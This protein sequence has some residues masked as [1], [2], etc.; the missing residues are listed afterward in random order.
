MNHTLPSSVIFPSQKTSICF[1]TVRS[2]LYI[3]RSAL[4]NATTDVISTIFSREKSVLQATFSIL[5]QLFGLTTALVGSLFRLLELLQREEKPVRLSHFCNLRT[6]QKFLCALPSLFSV[7]VRPHTE[8]TMTAGDMDTLRLLELL[9]WLEFSQSEQRKVSGYYYA[10]LALGSIEKSAP[11]EFF[12]N[13]NWRA[14]FLFQKWLKT[15]QI[16]WALKSPKTV[17]TEAHDRIVW[18]NAKGWLRIFFFDLLIDFRRNTWRQ[19]IF[20]SRHW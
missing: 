18:N 12:L 5:L 20:C 15:L 6:Q 7:K 16:N 14:V 19:R 3:L 9:P 10:F 17:S 4:R 2:A 11:N 8:L 1:C 13:S